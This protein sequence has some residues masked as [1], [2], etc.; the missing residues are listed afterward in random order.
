MCCVA[1]ALLFACR[2]CPDRSNTFINSRGGDSLISDMCIY[3]IHVFDG[4]DR[5]R[6]NHM[7]YKIELFMQKC[8]FQSAF[9]FG[10]SIEPPMMTLLKTYLHTLT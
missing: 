8:W 7:S 9:P 3:W 5:V 4:V 1:C 10:K 6:G 2:S